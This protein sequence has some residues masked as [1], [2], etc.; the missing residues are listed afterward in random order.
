MVLT[1]IV[2]PQVC[3]HDYIL[4]LRAVKNNDDLHIS[5]DSLASL[6]IRAYNRMRM[7]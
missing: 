1:Y 6:V 2:S 3:A 4:S 7:L 5:S